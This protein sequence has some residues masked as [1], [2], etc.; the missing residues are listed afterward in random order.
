MVI[1]GRNLWAEGGSL[2]IHSF[3]VGHRLWLVTAGPFGQGFFLRFKECIPI[4][5]FTLFSGF[6]S[7]DC[8]T[9]VT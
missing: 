3:A 2:V 4:D 5:L 8:G 9:T 7:S 1:P 6:W